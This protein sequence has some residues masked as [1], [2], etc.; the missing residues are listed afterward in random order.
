[1]AHHNTVLS[2]LL[3]LIPR[4]EFETLAKQHHC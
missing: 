2:Q 1:M 3:K 4:H